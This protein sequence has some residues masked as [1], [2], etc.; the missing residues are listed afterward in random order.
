MPGNDI[1]KRRTNG[2][3]GV[4]SNS[5]IMRDIDGSQSIIK[6]CISKYRRVDVDLAA[7]IRLTIPKIYLSRPKCQ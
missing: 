3:D 5:R 4:V 2:V 1:F 6:E 7:S